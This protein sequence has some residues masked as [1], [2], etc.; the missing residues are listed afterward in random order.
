MPQLMRELDAIT[1]TIE[2]LG[3]HAKFRTG[4]MLFPEKHH[5]YN[6]IQ[7]TRFDPQRDPAIVQALAQAQLSRLNR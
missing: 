5:K 3:I 4:A 7:A 2:T 1:C 6:P